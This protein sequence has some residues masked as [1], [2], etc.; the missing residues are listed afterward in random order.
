MFSL[1]SD[2][3]FIFN[4]M[5]SDAMGLYNVKIDSSEC[6]HLISGGKTFTSSHSI[7]SHRNILTNTTDNP[8][9]FTLTF[10][11]MDQPFTA[12][13]RMQ[14]FSY[15]DVKDYC[16][17]S[18][19]SDN[20]F[21]YNVL[22]MTSPMELNLFAGDVGYFSIDFVCDASHG[23][24]DKEYTYTSDYPGAFK[25]QNVG[26]VRNVYGNY[27]VYPTMQ[28][29]MTQGTY[30]AFC[31][32]YKIL[33][34]YENGWINGETEIYNWLTFRNLSSPINFTIDNE[35]KQVYNDSTNENLLPYIEDANYNFIGL[36]EGN[37]YLY[38]RSLQG[39]I[40]E[41]EINIKYS[42]PVAM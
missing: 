24:I 32:Q 13:K 11:A 40:L 18:F 36:Q 12:D 25:V 42:C 14:I 22:P 34:E 26:N 29:S 8:L 9:T 35:N 5:T 2:V 7:Y 21:Y 28:I 15:F 1:L 10:T 38:R 3:K 27:L 30:V 31:P 33:D 19:S 37:T 6:K 20:D 17:L 4:G 41:F 23:W 39:D 16:K